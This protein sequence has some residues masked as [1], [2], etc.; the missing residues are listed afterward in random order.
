MTSPIRVDIISDVVCPWCIVGFRQL[1]LAS[2]ATKIEV[3]PFWHPFELNPDMEP[4]GENLR[5]HIMRKYGSTAEQSQQ[6][7][8]NLRDIGSGLEIAF[9]FNDESRIYNTFD[10]HKLLHWAAG[11]GRAHDLKMA[12]FT[13][14]FAKGADV[15]N[16]ATLVEIAANAGFDAQ[17]A[18]AARSDPKI[19]AAV[20]EK[21]TFWTSRG[22]QGVPAMVFENKHLVTGAQGVDNYQSILTQLAQNAA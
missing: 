18:L 21:E 9:N 4:V 1:Q 14:Y 8:D 19:A 7:R 10:A 12:F 17:D 16:Q 2:V 6:A 11:L 5:D 3:Q 20:R 15:S 13:A 22:V